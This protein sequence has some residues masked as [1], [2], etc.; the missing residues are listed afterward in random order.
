MSVESA[1]EALTFL[2]RPQA[3]AHKQEG[4]LPVGGGGLSKAHTVR[5]VAECGEQG[6]GTGRLAKSR[7][8]AA[9]TEVLPAWARVQSLCQEPSWPAWKRHHGLGLVD[10][11]ELTGH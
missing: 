3:G 10:S 6:E 7:G 8:F 9:A 2:V 4:H 5:T 11:T 1:L